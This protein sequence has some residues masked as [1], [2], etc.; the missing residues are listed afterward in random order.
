MSCRNGNGSP[1][2]IIRKAMLGQG[3]S[4]VDLPERCCDVHGR[5]AGNAGL[6]CLC[7]HIH[8]H[9]EAVAEPA[10]LEHAAHATQFYG[11][12]TRTARGTA[13]MM[14]PNVMQRVDALIR[15]DRDL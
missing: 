10:R 4:P 11:L 9:A 1:G 3:E 7:R 13:I 8:L 14:Q 5:S 12:E 2:Q 15:P 6:P